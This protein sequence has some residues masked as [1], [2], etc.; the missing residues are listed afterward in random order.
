MKVDCLCG[1][2]REAG[3]YLRLIDSCSLSLSLK[4]LV[5]PVTRAKKKKKFLPDANLL[6][7][8]GRTDVVRGFT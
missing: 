7:V 3:W 8:M 4:D 1:F 2:S 5:G 6:A